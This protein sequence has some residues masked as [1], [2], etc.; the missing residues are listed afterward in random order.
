MGKIGKLVKRANELSEG[1]QEARD[2]EFHIQFQDM[3]MRCVNTDFGSDFILKDTITEDDVQ[4]FL[5]SFDEDYPLETNWS[6]DEA[7]AELDEVGDQQMELAKDKEME[8]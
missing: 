5:N 4:G 6:W 2:E 1:Y 7:N 3:F 8:I